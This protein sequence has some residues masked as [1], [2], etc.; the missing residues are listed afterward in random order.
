MNGNFRPVACLSLLWGLIVSVSFAG[1]PVSI[2]TILNE[3][4][5]YQSQTVTIQGIVR[6]VHQLP[7]FIA[8][9]GLLSTPCTFVLD[10][11]TGVIEVQVARNC[12]L[13]ELEVAAANE[14]RF[15][16]EARIRATVS[17]GVYTRVEAVASA[18]KRAVKSPSVIED[19]LRPEPGRRR[20]GDR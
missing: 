15:E 19:P 5:A 4:D 10:D 11:G 3:L 17:P 20:S 12:P 7:P 13:A 2:G 1:E 9:G 18:L 16:V 14:G 8:H 6:Q